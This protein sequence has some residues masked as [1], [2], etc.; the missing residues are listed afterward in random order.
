MSTPVSI[1]LV[2]RFPAQVDLAEVV[3]EAEVF[4]RLLHVLKDVDE[5]RG[6]VG[7]KRGGRMVAGRWQVSGRFCE[8]SQ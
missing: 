3:V 8:G 2:S 7:G 4:P 5:P 6:T 1:Y